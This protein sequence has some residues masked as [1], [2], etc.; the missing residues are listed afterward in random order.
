MTITYLGY[1]IVCAELESWDQKVK[2]NHLTITRPK[3]K[4]HEATD[5]LEMWWP[6]KEKDGIKY[7]VGLVDRHVKAMT[8]T[9]GKG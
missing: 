9:P 6:G 1:K 7:A 3:M 4:G 5:M 2:S 8:I